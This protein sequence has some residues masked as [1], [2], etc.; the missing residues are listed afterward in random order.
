MIEN[1]NSGADY[2][3]IVVNAI[4]EEEKKLPIEQ[5]MPIGILRYLTEQVNHLANQHYQDY[6]LGKRDTFMFSDVELETM[7]NKAGELYVGD[8][9]DEAV[10]NNLMQTYIGET[11]EILYGLSEEG[12]KE[13]KKIQ[14]N[15]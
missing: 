12:K 9:I 14:D 13:L 11:G 10:D 8:L 2:A 5:Q 7:F 1:I 3:Q 6:I 4:L 15:E